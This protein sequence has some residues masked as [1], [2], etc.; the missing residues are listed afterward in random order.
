MKRVVKNDT[1]EESLRKDNNNVGA[2]CCG[3]VCVCRL[4]AHLPA[5]L[6]TPACRL[7]E[8]HTVY[9]YVVAFAGRDFIRVQLSRLV[10]HRKFE[11]S[12]TWG[13]VYLP[14]YIYLYTQTTLSIQGST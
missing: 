14:R 3:R 4:S 9:A 13:Q 7:E 10:R 11:T 1:G 5:Y 2:V 8:V 6:C 12:N